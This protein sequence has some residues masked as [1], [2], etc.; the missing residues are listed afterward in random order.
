MP[1]YH[2]TDVTPEDTKHGY[3][4]V[5]NYTYYVME[6]G[7]FRHTNNNLAPQAMIIQTGRLDA[8]I[9]RLYDHGLRRKIVYRNLFYYVLGVIHS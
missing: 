5:E 3:T 9:D 6:N 8:D 1:D 2:G 7:V 4:R